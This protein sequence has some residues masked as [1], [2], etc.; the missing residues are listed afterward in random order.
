MSDDVFDEIGSPIAE[1]IKGQFQRQRLQSAQSEQIRRRENRE[2]RRRASVAKT[3]AGAN[4][5]GSLFPSDFA[6]SSPTTLG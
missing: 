5:Q 4:R 6:P 3:L 2:K 1:N